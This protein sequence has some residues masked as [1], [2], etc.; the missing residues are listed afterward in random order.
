MI[1]LGDFVSCGPF[2]LR[3]L[4]NHDVA[5]S[6]VKGRFQLC[7]FFFLERGEG[8]TRIMFVKNTRTRVDDLGLAC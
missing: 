6:A 7:C 3:S 8:L 5:T 2:F 1:R 4:E